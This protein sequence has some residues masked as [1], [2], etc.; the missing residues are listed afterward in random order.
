MAS[1]TVTR[2]CTGLVSNDIWEPNVIFSLIAAL[3]FPSHNTVLPDC[4]RYASYT[5]NC[6]PFSSIMLILTNGVMCDKT[7]EM[8][9]STV[10]SVE[11]SYI[12][13][14]LGQYLNGF[15]DLFPTML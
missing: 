10:H 5:S 1:S 11:M 7:R 15:D 9:H 13:I 6:R 12:G 14:G 2:I 3:H 4:I 8:I